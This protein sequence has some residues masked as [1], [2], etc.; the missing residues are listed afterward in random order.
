MD[1]AH[2]CDLMRRNLDVVCDKHSSPVECPDALIAY[3][4]KFNEYGL[5]VHDGGKSSVLIHFCP[6]CGARLPE[7]LRD[8]W[9]EE[10][11]ALGFD[12]PLNQDIPARYNTAAWYREG[13]GHDV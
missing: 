13:A 7:S 5:I 12:E 6:W 3:S 10:L 2:C 4:E 1:T 11:E 8:R 9:F